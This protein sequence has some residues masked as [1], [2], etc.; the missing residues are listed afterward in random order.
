MRICLTRCGAQLYRESQQLRGKWTL[1]RGEGCLHAKALWETNLGSRKGSK[2]L[3]S[4]WSKD[5]AS[6]IRVEQD[7][8]QRQLRPD[9][10]ALMVNGR[11]APSPRVAE[12][13]RMILS[14]Q[15][16]YAPTYM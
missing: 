11:L 12:N 1:G 2:M 14:G 15:A 4:G 13:Q 16:V 5:P 8:A 3:S 7:E 6:V 10:Y 9:F